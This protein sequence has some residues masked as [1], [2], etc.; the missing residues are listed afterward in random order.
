MNNRKR[1]ALL[2]GQVGEYYQKTFIEGF[3]K[4]A[5]ERNYDVCV[6]SVYQKY[7]E[8]VLREVGECNIFN[9]VPY[10]QFDAVVVMADTILTPGVVLRIEE[11]LKR[12]F[13]G[14]VLYIE[15]ESKSYP[16]IA[17]DQRA[18]I[19]RMIDHL[20]E[21]HGYKDIA[22]VTGKQAHSH[23]K[24]R[25]QGFIDSMKAHGLEVGE[26]R[27]FYGDYWYSCG[28]SIVKA[29][30]EDREHMP[31]AIACANDYMAIGIAKELDK[32]GIRIPEDVAIVGYDSVEDGRTS[33][34]PITSIPTPSGP[35]GEHA[36]K[37][38][39]AMVEDTE[40][41]A[42]TYEEP[43]FIGSSCGCHNES[44][45]PTVDLRSTWETEV[46]ANAVNS[47]FNYL[48]EDLL[49]QTSFKDV[50]ETVMSYTYQI[51]PFESFNLCVNDLWVRDDMPA[52]TNII[53]QGYTEQIL[54]VLHCGRE[55]ENKEQLNYIA[56]FKKE[57]LLPELVAER[58]TAA[59]Y[60][61]TP[62]YFD[63]MS[64]G[65]AAVSFGNQAKCVD[66][67]YFMWLRYIMLGIECFRRVDALRKSEDKVEK[68][69]SIDALTGMFNYEGFVKFSKAVIEDAIREHKC[70]SVIALD[71]VG[72]EQINEK[73]SRKE[74]DRAILKLSELIKECMD[75]DGICCR[76]GNDEFVVAEIVDEPTHTK[77]HQI[78]KHLDELL[79]EHNL[80]DTNRYPLQVST[81]GLTVQLDESADLEQ[82]INSAVS[83]KNGN[84]ASESRMKDSEKLS[85]EERQQAVVVKKILD[86]NLFTYHFQP[87]VC[88]RTGNIIAYEAL[89][90]AQVQPPI[91]PLDILKYANYLD[92]LNDVERATFFNILKLVEVNQNILKG[93][94]VFINSIPGSQLN[95]K[96]SKLLEKKLAQF[97]QSVVVE[98]T[99]QSEADDE[100]L[101]EMKSGYEQLG[102]QTAVDDYGTGY[103]NIVNLLRYMPNYVKIDRMLMTGIQDNP[104]KQHF[105]REIVKFAH[106]NDFQV[107]AEGIET[108]EELK[109]VISLD[110]D[111]IQGYY[112]ARPN[113]EI[114]MQ[115]SEQ[116]VEEIRA[117]SNAS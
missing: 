63:D 52:S 59:G 34:Q 114:L 31:E 60:F 40:L 77:I 3:F 61:F 64:F 81:G 46:S 98:L 26:N 80:D 105:V 87:I 25:L 21:V 66:E 72:L 47:S 113:A 75:Q 96:D 70:M 14:P 32:A 53:R 15:K 22:F 97:A 90:R 2:A 112:T 44:T 49:S 57:L 12:E 85:E 86:E 103:S 106:E 94:K 43:L 13:K 54:P 45:I 18:P 101:S 24:F 4:Q 23:S 8:S 89:M 104:Q 88:A 16:Y 73:Y 19:V 33:P 28:E 1:I 7:Q 10:D 117:Y 51:R 107:L 92:R 79:E 91:G 55:G 68:H 74:G 111:L 17:M 11:Q 78:R 83:R 20:I 27:V 41:P 39:I 38:I 110:V 102:V 6:F 93:K 67:F 50:I 76:L 36:A 58:D 82:I 84:K 37:C 29:L 115:I 42:F 5:F 69:Q 71:V 56:T 100:T 95:D 35:F 30:L 109:T 9:L 116:I 62:M 48:L 65:Y 108:A 99:E